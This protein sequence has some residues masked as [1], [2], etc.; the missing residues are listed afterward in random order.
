ML[1]PG[2]PERGAEGSKSSYLSFWGAKV[3]FMK[4][5]RTFLEIDMIQRRLTKLYKQAKYDWERE[6]FV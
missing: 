3:P 5:H 2:T 4:Y 6:L 1:E